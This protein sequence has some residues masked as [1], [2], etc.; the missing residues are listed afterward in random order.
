MWLGTEWK[1]TVSYVKHDIW[2]MT[3]PL[4]S[5]LQNQ[6]LEQ[7]LHWE[8]F[9]QWSI[10]TMV[11][12]TQWKQTTDYIKPDNNHLGIVRVE[13]ELLHLGVIIWWEVMLL[14]YPIQLL[15]VA[16]ATV[17]ELMNEFMKHTRYYFYTINFV[18][19]NQTI[20]WTHWLFCW[21][22][23]KVTQFILELMLKHAIQHNQT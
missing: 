16:P 19:Q 14:Q 20:S 17:V 18:H 12:S 22:C 6:Y 23:V 3:L 11:L 5:L 8:G 4:H 10:R 21:I 2:S 1:Q 7:I 15:V 9:S 13:P